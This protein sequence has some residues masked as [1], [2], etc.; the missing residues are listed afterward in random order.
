[1]LYTPDNTPELE[2]TRQGM[3]RPVLVQQVDLDNRRDDRRMPSPERGEGHDHSREGIEISGP[4]QQLETGS[5]QNE[6]TQS[7]APAEVDM[8]DRLPSAA[9]EPLPPVKDFTTDIQPGHPPS[10]TGPSQ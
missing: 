8:I 7:A 2:N 5:M 9:A 1:M 4:V 10:Q 6:V 3:K